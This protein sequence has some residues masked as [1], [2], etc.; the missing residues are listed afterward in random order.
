MYLG[1]AFILVGLGVFLS[2]ISSLLVIAMFVWYNTKYQILPEE[3]AL[4]DK[5]G[6]SFREYKTKVRRWI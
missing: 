5:F 2:S 1:F 3:K 4:E 6:E